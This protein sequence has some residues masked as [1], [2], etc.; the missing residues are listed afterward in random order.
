MNFQGKS[1]RVIIFLMVMVFYLMKRWLQQN[2]PEGLKDA[3]RIFSLRYIRRGRCGLHGMDE[4]LEKYL[5][6]RDGFFVELGANDGVTQSNTYFLEKRR[7][8]KGVLIEP[9]LNLFISCT[10]NRSDRNSFFCNACV[11]F[12]YRN[13]F[14]RIDY[15]KLRSV[16]SSLENDLE[17][18]DEFTAEGRSFLGPSQ[19]NIS[20]GA[21]AKPLSRILDEAGS[22]KSIDFL[23]L[24]VEGAELEVL[25]G[26][27]FDKYCIKYMLVECRDLERLSNFLAQ[28][29]YLLVDKLSYHDYLFSFKG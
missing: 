3:L 14:V 29:N 23:S 5:S 26:I 28:K 27:D 22:P 9:S 8:W 4:K 2:L 1:V 19:G 16:S 21:E 18:V 17:S 7:G 20:F 6:F 11:P 24:D 15:A 13:E 10:K 12:S 25:K